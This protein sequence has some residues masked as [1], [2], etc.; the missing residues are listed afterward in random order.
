[1]KTTFK[2]LGILALVVSLSACSKNENSDS[3]ISSENVAIAQE[4]LSTESMESDIS[5]SIN[6][7]I[8]VS[9]LTYTES[10]ASTESAMQTKSAAISDCT[11][12]SIKPLIGGFPKTITI[13]FGDGCVGEYGFT[14]SGSIAVTITDTLRAPGVQYSV[15]F[16]DFAIDG[17]TVT[18][19]LTVENTGT[20]SQPS[21]SED[22]DLTF[23]GTAGVSIHKT[24]TV[25]RAWIEG[26]STETLTDDVFQITGSADVESSNGY[27]YSYDITSPLKLEYAC[28]PIT[29]GV[30]VLTVSSQT[31]P[32]TI[33]FGNGTCDW[34]AVLS[35]LG[36]K[37]VEITFGE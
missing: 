7:A 12:I 25:D 17:Y 15:V 29:E 9:E 13:D 21:F 6:S 5:S 31:D 34:K 1:M 22:M 30:I 24:K 14:R 19:T 18:G 8:L 23:T 36:K 27:A 28:D 26:A 4:M 32:I 33:D 16:T 10:S 37:D 3:E 35:Q 11:D 2:T 20:E